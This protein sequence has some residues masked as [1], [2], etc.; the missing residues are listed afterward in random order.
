M[1]GD[2][3]ECCKLSKTVALRLADELA[4]D[5]R[6]EQHSRED[7]SSVSVGENIVEVL[8]SV[9]TASLGVFSR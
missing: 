9:V 6:R 3:V 7:V 8:Y 5:A 1:A 4:N 2:V